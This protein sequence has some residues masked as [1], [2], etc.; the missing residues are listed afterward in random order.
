VRAWIFQERIFL[1]ISRTQKIFSGSFPKQFPKKK[2]PET[3][4][5]IF[6]T[7]ATNARFA[8]FLKM[9]HRTFRETSCIQSPRYATDPESKPVSANP[10]LPIHP[11]SA[12]LG[13]IAGRCATTGTRL[14]KTARETA[15]PRHA[16]T[17]REK[18]EALGKITSPLLK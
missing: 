17:G 5:K 6:P 7:H 13:F 9:P 18:C 3:S 10:L 8:I 11:A 12:L 2:F 14:H 16:G 4:Q 1:K 15:S